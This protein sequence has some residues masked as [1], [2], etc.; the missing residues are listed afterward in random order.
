MKKTTITRYTI[1]S[2]LIIAI[3]TPLFAQEKKIFEITPAVDLVSSYVWRGGYETGASIQPTLTFTYDRLSLE[4]WGSTDFS[5]ASD[6]H[7]SKEINLTLGYEIKGFNVALIDY[8]WSGE[9]ARY[10]RYSTD[11][12]FEAVISYHFGE[13]FPLALSWNT[14][15]AGGDKNEK[16]D[17][18]YSTYIEAT[19]DF[20]LLGV[21]LTP[22]IGISPWTGMYNKT[23]KTG[24]AIPAISL[25]ATKEIR[26]TDTFSLPLFTQAVVSPENDDVFLVV[27]ISF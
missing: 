10:G 20:N 21:E 8:W 6:E 25:T 26:I 18:N 14:F 9:G 7:R 1:T 16:G 27:G 17:Q 22:A 11:H 3:S 24:F 23:G 2:I 12:Y 5:T 19:Y 15:F 13:S 4:A